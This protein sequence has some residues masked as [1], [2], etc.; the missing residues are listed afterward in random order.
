M[1]LVSPCDHR[2]IKKIHCNLLVAVTYKEVPGEPE[3]LDCLVEFINTK[4]APKSPN[5][6]Q[7]GVDDES[8]KP[9]AANHAESENSESSAGES[10]FGR[11]WASEQI[12]LA[13]PELP[14]LPLL[15]GYVQVLGYVRLNHQ[16]G[17]DGVSDNSPGLLWKN[18]EYLNQYAPQ[19]LE[20]KIGTVMQTPFFK[21]HKNSSHIGG[22]PDLNCRRLDPTAQYLVHDLVHSFNTMPMPRAS[23]EIND[24]LQED[25]AREVAHSIV[26]FYVTPQHLLFSSTLVREGLS[27][28]FCLRVPRPADSLPPSYNTKLTGAAGDSG[29]VSIGYLFVVGVLEEEEGMVSPRAVYFPMELR[30]GR[31]GWDREWLQHDYLQNDTVDK[32]WVVE[33]LDEGTAN[34]ILSKETMAECGQNGVNGE[35]NGRG[36]S[37]SRTRLLRDL[38]TLIESDIHVVSANE[39]RKSSVSAPFSDA[40]PLQQ[41]PARLRV[42][43]QIRVNNQALCDMTVSKPFYHV[44]D[45]VDFFMEFHSDSAV[46]TRVVGFTVHIEAHEI[47]HVDPELD[48]K[49]VNAYKVTPTI[50]MNTFAEALG[51]AYGNLKPGIVASMVNLPKHLTQQFQ[52]STFMDLKYFL[53]C[54]FVLSELTTPDD[55]PNVDEDPKRY[56]DYIQDYKMENES[57]EFKFRVPLTVL[58]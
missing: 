1:P 4:S 14:E 45:D 6:E 50:K 58:P 35:S 39:R 41:V 30:P 32:Q 55:L 56:A 11:F 25:L 12:P 36:A 44:G 57:T 20:E 5:T 53:M 17:G 54:K 15:L 38:D 52:S 7:T 27:E 22:I 19:E 23:A 9:S 47:F 29:L 16:I 48:R 46:S 28:V 2:L 43:Y 26:P 51:N 18:R 8:G 3:K 42:L 40:G 31:K 21:S 37:R 33:T 49:L 24:S 10:W 34:G 13:P